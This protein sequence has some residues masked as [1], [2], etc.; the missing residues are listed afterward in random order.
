MDSNLQRK[1]CTTK[2]E[3]DLR[4]AYVLDYRIY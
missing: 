2:L 4:V 1:T 3:R